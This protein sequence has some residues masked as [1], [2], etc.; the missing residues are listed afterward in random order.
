MTMVAWFGT[1]VGKAAHAM[2]QNIVAG[3][4]EV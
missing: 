3:A 4:S 2:E 1:A